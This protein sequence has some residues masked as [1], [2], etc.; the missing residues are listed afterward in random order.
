M[1]FDFDPY[2]D[3]LELSATNG[4]ITGFWRNTDC[5]G[6]DVPVQGSIM[7]GPLGLGG[8]VLCDYPANPCPVGHDWAFFIDGPLD[9][10]MQMYSGPGPN[11]QL[12]LDPLNYV[13]IPGPCP[14][15]PEPGFSNLQEASWMHL[16]QNAE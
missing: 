11:W 16:V 13:S 15:A 6:T 2:C 4:V 1:C 14:F 8:Y 9:G 10:T 7:N 3:G 12:W 5:A